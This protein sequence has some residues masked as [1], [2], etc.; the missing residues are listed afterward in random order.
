M[1]L[2]IAE[3]EKLWDEFLEV[4]PFER[5]AT[6]SLGEYTKSQDKDSFCYWLKIKTE[7]LGSMWGG[8]AFKFGIYSRSSTEEKS[9]GSGHCYS[10]S[11][12]WLSKYGETP[13]EAFDKVRSIVVAIAS[14]SRH[15]DLNS[16]ESADLGTVTKWKIAFLYQDREHPCVLPLL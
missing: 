7:S 14:A 1:S 15:G 5:L 2:S 3:R 4:W 13:D 11:H 16:I 12:A 9:N 6:M 8:S 10:S